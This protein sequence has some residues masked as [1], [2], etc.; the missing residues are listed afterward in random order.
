MTRDEMA[1][2][3]ESEKSFATYVQESLTAKKSNAIEAKKASISENRISLSELTT[4]YESDT[5]DTEGMED[6]G[7][8]VEIYFDRNEV[9]TI[10]KI[11]DEVGLMYEI[12]D[13]YSIMITDNDINKIDEFMATLDEVGIRYWFGAEDETEDA[14][15]SDMEEEFSIDERDD[16]KP[17]KNFAKIAKAAAKRYGSAEAGRRVAGAIRKKALDKEQKKK[18]MNE[19]IDLTEEQVMDA[20]L[21]I[22]M[23]EE[24]IHEAVARLRKRTPAQQ[25]VAAHQYYLKHKGQIKLRAKKYRRTASFKKWTRKYNIRSKVGRTATGKRTT[26]RIR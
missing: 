22:E 3:F 6:E 19:E 2:V 14:M 7:G 18:K 5:E 20:I 9:E 13:G 1:A 25:R 12:D 26:A 10:I 15:E 21:E 24:D 17:G 8:E 23:S 4:G 11:A 16:G